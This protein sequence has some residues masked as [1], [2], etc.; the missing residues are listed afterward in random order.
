MKMGK[1]RRANW[2][3]KGYKRKRRKTRFGVYD[4]HYYT[5]AGPVTI[6]KLDGSI[7]LAQPLSKEQYAKLLCER[8]RITMTMRGKV[9]KRDHG[10]CRYCGTDQGPFEIDHVV[11]VAMGGT[12]AFANLVT[13]C[14]PCNNRK[15]AQVWKPRKIMG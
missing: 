10:R 11:P 8:T 2:T 4:P 1:A 6:K 5:R 15:G 12:G 7:E 9:L 14:H 3:R 13:A